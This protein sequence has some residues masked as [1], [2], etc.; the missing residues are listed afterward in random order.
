MSR[1][2]LFKGLFT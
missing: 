2:T 1:N